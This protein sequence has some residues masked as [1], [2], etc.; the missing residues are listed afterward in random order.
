MICD[1]VS[2]GITYQKGEWNKSHNLDYYLTKE[3]RELIH[4]IIDEILIDVYTRIGQ[5]GLKVINK[6]EL[7]KIYYEH[8][9]SDQN[10]QK[11]QN[12]S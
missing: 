5:E 10:D 12:I 11:H 3:H 2:A 7:K 4:P 6:K 8:V 9:R 1:T